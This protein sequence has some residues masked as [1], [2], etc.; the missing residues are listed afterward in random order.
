LEP[1]ID[2]ETRQRLC[3]N[4]YHLRGEHCV[5][6]FTC[7]TT[8]ETCKSMTTAPSTTSQS[9]LSNQCVT[10]PRANTV[11][12]ARCTS[13]FISAVVNMHQVR[14]LTIPVCYGTV[15]NVPHIR[16]HSQPPPLQSSQHELVYSSLWPCW[17]I[18][19]RQVCPSHYRVVVAGILVCKRFPTCPSHLRRSRMRTEN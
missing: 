10:E 3:P 13:S 5:A 12:D 17:W 6:V 1:L 8:G 7:Q 18:H 9:R 4:P 15:L 14:M 19:S 16:I 11:E 2:C